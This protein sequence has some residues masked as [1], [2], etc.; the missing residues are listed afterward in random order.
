MAIETDLTLLKRRRTRIVAT[1][2]PAS[3]EPAVLRQLMQAGLDVVR[4]NFSHGTHEEHR[5]AYQA[6]RAAAAEAGRPVAVLADLCGPKIRVGL[7]PGGPV[8]LVEGRELTITTRQVPGTAE[9]ICSQYEALA[10]DVRAGDRILLDDGAMELKVLSVA[11][12]EIRARVVVG[13]VLKDKKGMNM[14]G[15]AVSAPAL[16]EKDRKDAAFA[17]SLGVDWIALSFVQKTEDVLELRRL[18]TAAGGQARIIAKIEK[19]EA[20]AAIDGILGASDGIMVA[21]GDLGVELPLQQVPIAQDQL[22]SLARA[23]RKPVI[24]A[25]QMLESMITAPRPTRAEVS[26]VAGAVRAGA[27][28]VMLSAETAAGRYPVQAVQTMDLICRQREAWEWQQGAFKA[29]AQADLP[30]G[31]CTIEDAVTAATA[32]L[33]RDLLVRAIIVGPG[34]D[35]AVAVMSAMRPGSPIVALTLEAAASQRDALRWGVLPVTLPAGQGRDLRQWANQVATEHGLAGSGQRVLLVSGF[36]AD[37]AQHA[38]SVTV[39]TV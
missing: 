33:S 35:Q 1:I 28:A 25:T 2:G 7:F 27:D 21:R 22:I 37:P 30:D 6:V 19:P 29:F 39:V 11:G 24:V 26:D 4:M 9:L 31:Q 36:S 5:A 15:V 23:Q 18:I 10:S 16:T 12:T 17:L 8:T 20:L 14:P 13:G 3:R 32:Q 38:P 34:Q